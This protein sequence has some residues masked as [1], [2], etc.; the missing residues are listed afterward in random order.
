[1]ACCDDDETY[2]S[3]CLSAAS[4]ISTPAVHK[5]SL[6]DS[7]DLSLSVKQQAQAQLAAQQA[8]RQEEGGLRILQESRDDSTF[9]LALRRACAA[10]SNAQHTIAQKQHQQQQQQPPLSQRQGAGITSPRAFHHP[11]QHLNRQQQ[12]VMEADRPA[13]T[14]GTLRRRHH[15]P[16]DMEQTRQQ[17]CS[18]ASV[19]FTKQELAERFAAALPVGEVH[20]RQL[21]QQQGQHQQHRNQQRSAP[22]HSSVTSSTVTGHRSA[23]PAPAP[24]RPVCKAA[25]TVHTSH[26]RPAS[27]IYTPVAGGN[28]GRGCAVDVT[29][30]R[31]PWGRGAVSSAQRERRLLL[32]RRAAFAE[33]LRARTGAAPPALQ[34]RRP[35][36]QQHGRQAKRA[37][38]VPLPG[39]GLRAGSERKQGTVQQ[40]SG[41]H[42]QN[43]GAQQ[44][45]LEPATAAPSVGACFKDRTPASSRSVQMTS[46][47][48][49]ATVREQSTGA[50]QRPLSPDLSMEERQLMASLAR[51]DGLLHHQHAGPHAAAISPVLQVQKA[52]HQ[53][54][55]LAYEPALAA[56]PSVVY[57][58]PAL[59]PV[60]Q[61]RRES[62]ACSQRAHG[63]SA[64]HQGTGGGKV[65]QGAHAR[66]LLLS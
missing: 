21:R 26:R 61:W 56:K 53:R 3:P 27:H 28:G 65:Y 9:V 47:Q 63:G 8:K 51:L 54:Q 15:V 32:E 52:P 13:E 4:G 37:P 44:H 42:L 22:S 2:P 10:P 19:A 20:P 1:M 31:Q 46:Q 45:A 62:V 17:H 40:G 41:N 55:Q 49:S 39:L 7:L 11:Q 33:T 5:T 25:Y 16:T 59:I 14:L 43:G 29:Q 24:A 57:A 38:H 60:P 30:A 64:Q 48:P 35:E 12:Q 23:A 18:G 58:E 6:V 50:R 36:Q 66:H 34:P